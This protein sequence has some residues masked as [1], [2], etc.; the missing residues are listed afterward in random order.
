MKILIVEDEPTIRE[1]IAGYLQKEGYV[2]EQA[3]DYGAADEKVVLYDYDLIVLDISLPG[4]SGL[5]VLRARHLH[6]PGCQ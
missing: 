3:A 1:T 2:C 4:G 5:D 6:G